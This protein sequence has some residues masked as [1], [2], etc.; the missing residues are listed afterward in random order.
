MKDAKKKKCSPSEFP[1]AHI[2][3]SST[4]QSKTQ[5]LFIHC[6]KWQRKE[7]SPFIYKGGA[8]RCLPLFDY[9][10][11]LQLIFFSIDYFINNQLQLECE[12]TTSLELFALNYWELKGEWDWDMVLVTPTW[13]LPALSASKSS[14]A[15]EAHCRFKCWLTPNWCKFPKWQRCDTFQLQEFSF[16]C[17]G[18]FLR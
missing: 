18:S 17:W 10:S 9:Q 1:R 14:T 6:H 13:W 2:T 15:D 8:R 5:T 7:V 11:R 12:H 4:Q 16:F 3:S